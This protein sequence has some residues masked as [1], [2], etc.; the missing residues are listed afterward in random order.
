MVNSKILRSL[1]AMAAVSA[2]LTIAAPARAD[3]IDFFLT[4]GPCTGGCGAGTAPA[5]ITA[6]N[7]DAVEVQV[8][9]TGS[10]PDF[11][12]ATVEFIG[13]NNGT[14]NVPAPTFIN[15]NGT[16]SATVS[17]AGGVTGAGSPTGDWGTFDES[18]S[19]NTAG[20]ITY[21]LTA[22]GS[23]FWTDAAD[24]LTPTTGFAAAYSHG[25]EAATSTT[26]TGKFAG[27]Y[28]APAPLIGHGL[29]VLLTTGGVLFGGRLL[30]RRKNR[31]SLGVPAAA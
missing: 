12:G 15:V 5:P 31:R 10:G 1:S 3:T 27:Y 11:T 6:S 7:T 20:T 29:L 22:T 4:Q 13:L 19:A 23:N 28:S 8:S 21:T 18:N 14:T 16:F 9:T 2:A 25:F 26:G 30:E 24:V 17:V